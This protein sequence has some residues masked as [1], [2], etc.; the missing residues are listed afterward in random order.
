MLPRE[1]ELA[2]IRHG[3]PDRIPVDAICIENSAALAAHLG[4]AEDEVAVRLGLDGRIVAAGAYTGEVPGR[5]RGLDEW[6]SGAFDDYGTGHVFPL[7]T[8][9]SVAEVER[10]PWPDPARYDYEGAA[11]R[12]RQLSNVYAV[13]GPYWVPLFCRACS[14]MGMEE[15]LAAM[16][17][18]PAV[19]EAV[20]ERVTA[21][22]EEHCRRFLASAGGGVDILCIGDDFATQRGLAMQPDLWRRF[23]K[24]RLARIFA[25]GRQAGKPVWFHSC[26]DVTAVLPD[27]IDIGM[28]VWETVQLHAL[29]LSARDLKRE[30]GR[31]IAFFGG[32]NTQRLPRAS[33]AE[34]AEEVRNCIE[35]LGEGGGYICGPDHHVKPD[36]PA[37]V[38]L[39]LFDAARAFRK[40]GFTRE[41]ARDN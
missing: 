22:V 31:H 14:L 6:G 15:A 27:L 30:Y 17:L 40:P 13:R 25:V 33:P 23:L 5:D 10:H 34:V 21:H 38:T 2:A 36:V 7:G 16:L 3:T 26:G 24:Q 12:A 35:A 9:E 19:F 41:R 11:A 20:L 4:I 39:A 18:R 28:D 1:R 8:A 32:V 37:A 29:P